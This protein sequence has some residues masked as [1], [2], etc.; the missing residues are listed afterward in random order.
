M[1][2][3]DEK[4]FRG[5]DRKR[6]K[7]MDFLNDPSVGMAFSILTAAPDKEPT[8]VPG[9]PLDT[10]CAHSLMKAIGANSVLK[11]LVRMTH[12]IGR[13]PEEQESH[14]EQEWDHAIPSGLQLPPLPEIKPQPAPA[15]SKAPKTSKKK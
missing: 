2:T 7:L 15:P 4:I 6:A 1:I 11:G 10:T 9:V 8:F 3:Q 13:S 14:E 12:P 5:D